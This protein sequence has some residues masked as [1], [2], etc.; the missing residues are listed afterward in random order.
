LTI[1]TAMAISGAAASPNMGYHS[2]PVLS[3]LLTLF[4]ARL[5]WWLGTPGKYGQETYKLESPAFA[6][7]PLLAEAFGRTDRTHPYVYASDGGHFENLGLYEMVRR[8]CRFI[9]VVDAGADPA[10]SYEDLSGAIRKVRS[11]MGIS[12]EVPDEAQRG[13][14][15]R[16]NTPVHQHG[17]RPPE[18]RIAFLGTIRYSDVD[19]KE[20]PLT[21]AVRQKYDGVLVYIKPAFYNTKEPLDVVNY[22]NTHTT[23]P[24]ETT[25]DQFFSESQFESYRALGLF[26]VGR[27]CETIEGRPG[28]PFQRF[29][30]SVRTYVNA[31]P[32]REAV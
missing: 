7:Q 11:D 18:L 15:S 25:A 27:M 30:A 13:I 19:A 26:A 22:A 21:A 28:T 14:F 17:G 1:G 10:C 20:S 9:L 6:L 24:H 3:F 29:L 32:A 2:S 4:N 31:A 12:I 16:S 23:F 8:R 5:G